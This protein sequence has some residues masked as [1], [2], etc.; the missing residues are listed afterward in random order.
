MREKNVIAYL[1]EVGR[2]LQDGFNRLASDYGVRS[3]VEC[4]GL[5][6]RS[7]VA[8][9]DVGKTPA[10]L[11]KSLFQQEAIKRGVLFSGAHCLCY[12]HTAQDMEY[13]L[14][15]YQEAFDVLVR[16]IREGNIE[17]MIE[18]RPVQPVFRAVT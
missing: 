1:W 5:P 9:H 6:P 8:F 13:T 12:S 11:V 4:V 7:F 10:L 18:G 16:A 17:E 3:Y 2:G 14:G 15:A